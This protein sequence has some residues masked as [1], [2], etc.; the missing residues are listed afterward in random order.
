MRYILL[1]LFA[2]LAIFD[3]GAQGPP[4]VLLDFD[5][6]DGTVAG[7]FTEPQLQGTFGCD[8]GVSGQSL[9][10]NSADSGIVF[11]STYT[12]LF[13][14]DFTLSFYFM[15]RSNSSGIV[16]VFSVSES[17]GIDSSLTI[18]YFPDEAL[19]QVQMARD[20]QFFVELEANLNLDQCWHQLV[21]QRDDRDYFLFIDGELVDDDFGNG[22]I[23]LN[24]EA[25]MK[26]AASPCQ[27][28]GESPFRGKIDDLKI[29]SSV[30]T[31]EQVIQ[32]YQE[33]DRLVTPDTTIFS[34]TSLN[35]EQLPSCADA[36]LWNPITTV[37][38]PIDL[39]PLLSPS[40]TTKYF[41]TYDY[42]I[43]R[44]QDSITVSIIDEE[45]VECSNLLL[46]NAFTPNGDG[47]NDEYGI[48]NI[49]IIE[50]LKSFQIFDRWGEKVFETSDK[51][52]KWDGTFRN[53]K[54]NPNIYLYKASYTCRD[55]EFVKTGS[56]S[57][58]R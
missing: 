42:T 56:F 1:I 37:D 31:I 53:K 32:N 27:A 23:T 24:P 28:F 48:S 35:I 20:F 9:F 36:F 26:I 47:L 14:E 50:E 7:T 55:Q 25:T 39:E 41:V 29:Y 8:C 18:K 58:L 11:D 10:F 54:V 44:A 12:E 5:D 38:G 43:C 2:I 52:S 51:R 13:Q 6:C 21:F 16:D 3:L 19:I 34:G 49:F 45:N 40:S 22:D 4:V 57:I 46:P 30:L 17:C 33:R 15:L